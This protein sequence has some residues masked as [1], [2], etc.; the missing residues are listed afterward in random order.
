M[1]SPT[2]PNWSFETLRAYIVAIIDANDQRYDQRFVDSQTAVAAALA[3]ARIAV[4]AALSA[5]KEAVLKAEVASDKRFEGVNE[6][7]QTLADQQRTLIPR[8]EAEQR[9][10]GLEA[11]IKELK[12]ANSLRIGMQAG[13]KDSWGYVVGGVGILIAILT[14]LMRFTKP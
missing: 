5:A 13:A 9:I 8:I 11:Q 4:D 1:N 7:R 6:F 12:T 3:A 10:G 14:Y 2:A